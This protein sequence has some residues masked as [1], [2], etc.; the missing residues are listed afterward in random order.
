MLSRIPSVKDTYFQ[1]K[2]LTKVHGKPTY[3]TL[4]NLTTELKANA[5]SVP[6]TL[7]GRQNGHLGIIVS[8]VRYT[9]LAHTV[10]W[11]NPANPG[12]FV[13]PAAGTA[14][15]PAL[16]TRTH[17]ICAMLVDKKE[18][19]KSYSDQT[20]R[21]PI[22]S[23]HGNNYLFILYHQD[24]NTIHAVAIPNRQAASIRDAWE[25]THKVLVR[26]GHTPELHIL[27]NECSQDLKD[28]SEKYKIKFQR[29][30]PKE[31]PVNAAKRAIRTYKNHFVTTLCN[32][33]S[34]F[35]ITEWDRLLP[36]TALHSLS[37]VE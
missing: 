33:D 23:S 35:P 37:T 8:A 7:G 28:E 9:T 6:S 19:I 13:P 17:Q 4:Q 12:P 24:T 31:H 1:H 3:E 5:G 22:P 30:P 27:D 2:V 29:V 36:Q 32:P 25:A 10:P 26:Q 20:G 15:A 11:V 34:N 16:D 14:I 21:F 18:L